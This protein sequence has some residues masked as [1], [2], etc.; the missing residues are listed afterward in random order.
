LPTLSKQGF[1]TGFEIEQISPAEIR[2]PTFA[3]RHEMSTSGL[4]LFAKPLPFAENALPR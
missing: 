2:Q 1:L 3:L 4:T